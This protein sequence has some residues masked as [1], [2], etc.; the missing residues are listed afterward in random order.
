[1]TDISTE[2]LVRGALGQTGKELGLE[3]LVANLPGDFDIMESISS[4]AVVE[5][6]MATEA[7]I[8]DATG[9]YVALADEDLFDAQKSP[10]R[11]VDSWI[12][13]VNG[14]RANA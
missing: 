1:M 10:L 9:Q 12:A 4:F 3:H 5:L 7:A 8:E 2:T 11:R 13:F 6:L 14:Q